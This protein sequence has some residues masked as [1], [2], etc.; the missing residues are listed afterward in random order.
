MHYVFKSL[1]IKKKTGRPSQ[2]EKDAEKA[3]AFKKKT[4]L[5]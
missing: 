2:V 1:K 5:R 3:D 4:F